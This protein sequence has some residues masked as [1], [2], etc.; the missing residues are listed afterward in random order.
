M[1]TMQLPNV[2]LLPASHASSGVN[3]LLFPPQPAALEQPA[4]ILKSCLLLMTI[5]IPSAIRLMAH[6]RIA[7]RAL[8]ENSSLSGRLKR[9]NAHMDIVRTLETQGGV[10]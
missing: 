5:L 8:S 3:L 7:L 9:Y 1:K 4:S 10:Q 2:T 6:R